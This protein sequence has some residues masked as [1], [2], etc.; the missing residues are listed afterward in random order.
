MKICFVTDSF[1]K[2]MSDRVTGVQVQTYYLAKGFASAGHEVTFVSEAR[3]QR[4]KEES[5]GKLK[6]LRVN[7][8]G[9]PLGFL[10][11]SFEIFRLLR[12]IRPD[13]CYQRGR[14]YFGAVAAFACKLTGARFVWASAGEHGCRPG[15]YRRKLS[16]RKNILKRILLFPDASIRDAFIHYSIRNSHYCVVQTEMQ[17]D[18]L[19]RYF[20]KSGSI[21]PVAMP[22]EK[23]RRRQ[24]EERKTIFWLASVSAGKQ[25]EIFVDLATRLSDLTECDFVMAGP[26][27]KSY[28]QK[29]LKRAT[30]VRHLQYLGPLP[31]GKTWDLFAKARVFVNTSLHSSE[32]FPNTFVQSWFS[33]TPTVSLNIDPDQVISKGDLGSCSGSVDKLCDDVRALIVDD[34]LWERQSTNARRYAEENLDIRRIADRYLSLFSGSPED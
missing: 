1:L 11:T 22:H 14:S 4:V 26:A 28:R 13:I 8:R 2:Y 21:I 32:G 6:V 30:G 29:L 34:A 17:R 12:R 9:W 33:G 5:F 25:P 15:K 3:P 10:I 23:P 27:S 18:E 24:A 16:E 20:R 7:R 31:F 19:F